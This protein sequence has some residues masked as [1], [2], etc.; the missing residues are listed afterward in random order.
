MGRF[1][2]KAK[3]IVGTGAVA[4]SVGTLAYIQFQDRTDTGKRSSDD[5]LFWTAAGGGLISSLYW[6]GHLLPEG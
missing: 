4:V 5:I 3:I 6:L 1:G 2:R